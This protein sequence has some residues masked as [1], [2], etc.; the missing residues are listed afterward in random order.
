LGA[1]D[2]AGEANGARTL[3]L[4]DAI[5]E[6]AG[7]NL[8]R[9]HLAG[10]LEEVIPHKHVAAVIACRTEYLPY[11]IPKPVLQAY[12]KVHLHGFVTF[13]EQ[14]AAAV[15]YLDQR[16]IVRPAGP[17]LAPEFSHPLFLKAASDALLMRNEFTF[18]RGLRGALKILRF[19]LDS[20]GS[21]L[22]PTN[23]E[24]VD[25]SLELRRALSAFAAKMAESQLDCVPI[26]ESN[27]IVADAFAPRFPPSGLTWLDV[28]LRNGI[29]R[30]DP[31]PSLSMSEEFEASR[32]VVRIAFQRFQDHLIVKASLDGVTT[33]DELFGAG[34]RLEWLIKSESRFTWSGLFE[35]LS[36]Q[37]PE[38][39][40]IEL[41]DALPGNP[42][43]W[44]AEWDI[45]ESFIQS[46]RWRAVRGQ[47]GAS[48]FTDRSLQLLNALEEPGL[49]L[50][51][52]VAAVVEHPWNGDML[53]R[54]LWR[55][56]LPE[57]DRRWS[58][59]LSFATDEEGHPVHRIITWST[60]GRLDTADD[61]I[62]RLVALVLI[63]TCATTSRPIR[64]KAT[65]GLR[66]ILA[67]APQLYHG[68]LETFAGVDDAYI[69]E[70]LL[71][72]SYGAAC[73]LGDDARLEQI[74]SSTFTLIFANGQPPRHLL[75]RDY[76]LAVLELA[77]RFG[78]LP[79]DIDLTKAKP[80]FPDPVRLRAPSKATL[81]KRKEQV[82]DNRIFFSCGEYGD[83]GRYEIAS[84]VNNFSATRLTAA[85]PLTHQDKRDLF[86]EQVVKGD[87]SREKA[88]AA[89]ITAAD[90]I[91]SFDVKN[92]GAAIKRVAASLQ[93]AKKVETSFVQLLSEA[94]RARYINEVQRF[95][96][97]LNDP[98]RDRNPPAFDLGWAQRWITNRV[99]S[100]GWTKNRF[101][102]DHTP[103]SDYGG[104]RSSIERVGK[105]YQW[106]ALY[107]L[108]AWLTDTYWLTGS[109]GQRPRP[110]AYPTDTSFQRDVD[111]TLPSEIDIEQ[112]PDGDWWRPGLELP[113]VEDEELATWV[114]ANDPWQ[115]ARRVIFREDETGRQWITLCLYEGAREGHRD[116]GYVRREIEMR[117]QA[118][119]F[120]LCLLVE[121]KCL[122]SSFSAL[123]STK[124]LDAIHFDPPG[125]VDGP[126]WGELGWRAT[127][128][129]IGWEKVHGLP[130]GVVALKPV[131]EF[132]WESHLDASEPNGIQLRAPAPELIASMSL[133]YPN[134]R[135]PR[136]AK[137]AQGQPVFVDYEHGESGAH[138]AMIRRDAFDQFLC[139]QGLGCLWYVFGERNAWPDGR[140]QAA[141]RRRFGR[142][143][144]Y[145]GI[146]TRLFEWERPWD[147]SG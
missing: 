50:L 137:N 129:I 40:G 91:W 66:R 51:I 26:A 97:S 90:A 58:R 32:D 52:E 59:I 3:I 88:F 4:I 45:Q 96:F 55:W 9:H 20:V 83:F 79:A 23:A 133:Q 132:L 30:R 76:A 109:W 60:G 131:L 141:P 93:R 84:P 5:N 74:A 63:W 68:L 113:G 29:V 116:R 2:A 87:A 28:L 17:L 85:A 105:K 7:A 73:H 69:L 92:D 123:K 39:L 25:L 102:D 80:P 56:K 18:P 70:R 147:Q 49:S 142:F 126:F 103:R 104:Q 77:E 35:A 11:A 101:G 12:P 33:V 75:S 111:P 95:I 42:E 16:G 8:W 62:L 82:G 135:H 125:I 144:S 19:Y 15:Q 114:A 64:D 99:Y 107:E 86:E 117:R 37:V 120:A 98:T 146:K 71:A 65:K 27:R 31:D 145:D 47:S 10:F 22:L 38:R 44:W 127:Q 94:E 24:P 124:S 57:R 54:N 128:P 143:L 61:E 81:E 34:G 43:Q 13:A 115:E 46:I 41:I 14:E 36:V 67:R 140:L 78:R 108:L 53:H 1:L 89:V 134:P 118:L 72:A 21:N 100:L 119:L 138:A 136:M 130:E 48:T 6:G 139:D 112:P 122:A 110:Y 106:I 121:K